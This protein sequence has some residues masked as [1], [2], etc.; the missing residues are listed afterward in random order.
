MK[1][2]QRTGCKA[3]MKFI[4]VTALS[5]AQA[6]TDDNQTIG[7]ISSLKEEKEQSDYGTLELNQFI[8]NG[9]KNILPD[10]PDDIVFWSNTKSENDCSFQDNPEITITF[11]SQHSSAGITLYFAEDYPT[12][13]R[14]TWY[15][16][17]GSKL[18]TKTF[19][20]NR[21][22]FECVHQVQNYGKIVITFIKTR[23]PMRYIKLR[24]I[25]YGRYIQ[26]ESDV[27]KEAKV[28]E[29]VDETSATLSI[30]TAKITI[31]DAKNDFDIGNENGTWKSVQRTQEVTLTEIRNGEEIPVGTFFIDSSNFKNNIAGFELKDRIGL[32]DNYTF[33]NGRIY[34]NVLA[35]KLLEEIFECAGVTKYSIDDE[36]YNTLLSGYLAVQKCRE[37][38]QMICFA[39][40][41]VADDSRSD[42]VRVFKPDRYV[43]ST[44]NID[45]KFNGQTKVTLDDYVSGVTI[46]CKKYTRDSKESELYK[47]ILPAG[48]SKVVFSGPVVPDTINISVGTIIER[49][50]NYIIVN[51]ESAEKCIITGIKY[52]SETFACT[53]NIEHIDAGETENIKKFGT[54]TLYN[55]E[56]IKTV[57]KNILSYY[58]LRKKLDMKYILETE[59]VSNWVNIVDVNGNI[60]T[61]LIETQDISL[62]GGFIATATC[63]GY[64]TITTEPYFTGTEL[65]TGEDVII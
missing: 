61:T 9:S 2:M 18:E 15:S 7:D 25:L 53:E 12:E 58:S 27:I 49:K 40:A 57:A 42:T 8:L 64:S 28:H 23:L 24:Y 32:M 60:A 59:R 51:M 34:E 35:G 50:T 63:R 36:V 14:I 16:L 62:T 5:D 4:D 47:D 65:Y 48:K 20:P 54:I 17:L 30:N 39:C 26:W 13:L 46:E 33:Q 45:R 44:V 1:K 41:A 43:S 38:L 29:E 22:V 10:K 37:A 3:Q 56:I 31:L 52:V 11:T 19:Y 55:M 21:L 6:S